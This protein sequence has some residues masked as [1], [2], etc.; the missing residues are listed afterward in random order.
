MGKTKTISKIN[1]LSSRI[2]EIKTHLGNDQDLNTSDVLTI[3]DILDEVSDTTE[4]ICTKTKNIFSKAGAQ[5]ITSSVQAL[6][7]RIEEIENKRHQDDE[8]ILTQVHQI[9]YKEDYLEL[10]FSHLSAYDIEGVLSGLDDEIEAILEKKP[11]NERL[12]NPLIQ[13]IQNKLIDLHFRYDF[14]IVEELDENKNSYAHRLM[15]MASELKKTNPKKAILLMQKIDEMMDL[16][17]ISK[18]FVY[19]KIDKAQNL[20]DKLDEKIKNKIEKIIWRVKGATLSQMEEEK[21]WVLPA[22][23]MNYV[24]DQINA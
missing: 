3:T 15:L 1:E 18:M 5:N 8:E 11:F 12:I 7:G 17:W 6:F 23:L 9:A 21:K 2:K 4:K 24:A 16:V 14:P 19:G 22:V 10:N 20:Y 13:K